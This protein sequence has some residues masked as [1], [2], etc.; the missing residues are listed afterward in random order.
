MPELKLCRLHDPDFPLELFPCGS[1][2]RVISSVQ[3]LSPYECVNARSKRSMERRQEALNSALTDG[4]S[5]IWPDSGLDQFVQDL[6]PFCSNHR[7]TSEE[8]KSR[9]GALMPLHECIFFIAWEARDHLKSQLILGPNSTLLEELI[10]L[11]SAADYQA[12]YESV[13]YQTACRERDDADLICRT[14]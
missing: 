14:S 4:D 1:E 11:R 2:T 6:E 5:F 10:L 12:K 7:E 3:D 13:R 9:F 8:D